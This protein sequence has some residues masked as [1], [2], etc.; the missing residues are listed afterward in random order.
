MKMIGII[1]YDLQTATSVNLAPPNLE[2]MKLATYYR[3][4]CNTFCRLLSLDETEL[5]SYEKIYFFSEQDTAPLIPSAFLQSP[6][7]IYSGTAFTQRLY[8]PFDDEIIDY[9]IPRPAIYKEYL[10]Q[11]YQDG[12]KTKVIR[13]ILDDTYYRCYAGENKLP[14]PAIH[15]RKHVYLYDR[16]FFYEDWEDIIETISSRRPASIIRIHPIVCHQ[17]EQYFAVRQK[18]KLAR[19]NEIILNLDIPLDEIDYMLKKYKDQ[20]LADITPSSNVFITLGNDFVSN[21]QYYKDLIYKL[22]VL[23][24]FWSRAIPLKI[25]YMEPLVGYHDPLQP[26]SQAIEVWAR[27]SIQSTRTINDKIIHTSKKEKS[28][29]HEARDLLL[30]FHPHAKDLFNQTYQQLVERRYWRV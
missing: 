18:E 28:P 14:L 12:I 6:N 25:K 4:E 19:T 16:E 5:S 30:K 13:N 27:R 10:K 29:A 21:F 9:T 11:K 20:F 15:P 17:L 24:A 1:D 2:A 22:N 8:Q 7:V 23:Y 3:I 26:L